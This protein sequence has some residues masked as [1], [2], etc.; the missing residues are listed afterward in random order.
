MEDKI[1]LYPAVDF[2][3]LRTKVGFSFVC[4]F[5]FRFYLPYFFLEKEEWREKE[6]ERVLAGVAQWI[7]RWPANQVLPV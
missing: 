6:R 3:G 4:L 5:V 7:E 1:S 2:G